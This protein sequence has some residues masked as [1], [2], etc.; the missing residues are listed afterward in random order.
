MLCG[1]AKVSQG[2]IS[3]F[4]QDP[5][6]DVDLYSRI[7]VMT[8]HESTYE[9]LTGRGLVRLA[10][11]MRRVEDVD[12]AVRRAIERVDLADAANRQVRTYSRGMKQRIKLAATIVHEPELLLLD[13]PLNGADPRQRI[14][15]QQ[16]LRRLSDEGRTILISC[17]IL[18]EVELLAGTVLLM[19][20]G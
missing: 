8:E 6:Q 5:R 1:L 9:L 16:L 18:E 11:R 4:G 15:F 12:A 17:H 19:V 2:Q 13:E 20:N 10:A 3:V 14:H 7:G